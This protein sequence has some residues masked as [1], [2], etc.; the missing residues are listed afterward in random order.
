MNIVLCGFMGCGKSTVGRILAARLGLTFVDMDA[1]IEQ[2]DGRSVSA[3]FAADGEEHFRRLEHEACR[4]LSDKRDL[5]IATGGG[6]VLRQEN[7]DALRRGGVLVWLKVDADR[8]LERLKEDASRPLLQR[9]D[10]EQAVRELLASRAPFYATADIAVDA[11]AD[12]DTVADRLLDAL[13]A[14]RI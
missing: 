7:V 3:I 1:Y 13:S 11:N 10:K 4:T 5:V 9:P 12:A 2:T 8:V 14:L 6:A